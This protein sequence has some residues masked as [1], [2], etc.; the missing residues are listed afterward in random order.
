MAKL[1][2]K[3]LTIF[4]GSAAN[5]GQ[6]G[7]AQAGTKVTTTDPA[8]IQ[9]LT[10]WTQGWL[11]AVEGGQNIPPLEEF[12]GVSFVHSY[13]SAYLFQE[14]IAEYDSG[15][16]YFTNSIVKETGTFKLYG[17]IVD[18][19]LGNAL[20]DAAAWELLVDLSNVGGTQSAYGVTTNTGNAYVLTTTPSVTSL[21]SGLIL[22]VEFNAANTGAVTLDVGSTGVKNVLDQDGNALSSGAIVASRRYLMFYDGTEFIIFNSGSST[23][24]S[25]N[26]QIFTASGTYTPTSG[27][28]YADVEV[29]GGGGGG[30][31]SRS[32]AGGAGS[33]SKSLISAATMGASQTVTIGAA[34][35]GAA[36]A[37]T[38]GS[39]GGNSSLGTLVTANGGG[40]GQYS[41]GFYAE[42]GTGGTAGT[43]DIAIAGQAGGNTGYYNALVTLGIGGSTPYGSGGQGTSTTSGVGSGYGAGGSGTVAATGANGT[44]GV[45]IIT[46]YI[47]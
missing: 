33:Y 40:G 23:L 31:S 36:A 37:S 13:M 6:F 34:G 42:G 27:M 21:N 15:T 10:A 47:G 2:R 7:S 29:I 38:N 17:S 30:G 24:K 39:A 22:E 8:T 4:A 20:T 46:E 41:S 35:A 12:Q 28:V 18:N 25:V 11:D 44:A 9:A 45:V 1:T 5:N 19:N 16:T 43:G 26:R 32:G 14:G 3:T